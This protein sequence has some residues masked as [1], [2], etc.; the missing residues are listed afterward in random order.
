ML[1][2][3]DIISVHQSSKNFTFWYEDSIERL[4]KYIGKDNAQA[5]II[6]AVLEAVDEVDEI[7]E[8]RYLPSI[9]ATFNRVFRV[10]KL[11]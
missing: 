3:I 9:A 4:A 10:N 5:L 8:I 1:K 2:D 7:D 11:I 6:Y